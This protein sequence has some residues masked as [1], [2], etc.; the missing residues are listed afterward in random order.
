M[1]KRI[2]A[3]MSA[4]IIMLINTCLINVCQA[5][6]QNLYGDVQTIGIGKF[7]FNRPS[8]NSIGLLWTDEADQF[9]E[10]YSLFR[11]KTVNSVGTG[12][13][14]LIATIPS[15]KVTDG[16]I[17][18]YI[19]VFENAKPVQY[20]Y[21]IA[22]NSANPAK[23]VPVGTKSLIASNI[24]VCIDPGHY[25]GKNL[26]EDEY[27]YCEGDF[28]LKVALLLYGELRKYGIY[29]CLT[30][31]TPHITIAGFTDDALDSG[32]ISLR[33]EY[34]YAM[35]CDLFISL[36]TNANGENANGYP[37]FGQPTNKNFPIVIVNIPA[38]NNSVI[39]DMAN[40]IGTNLVNENKKLGIST[41]KGYIG[42]RAGSVPSWD[43]QLNDGINNYGYT[44]SRL[45]SKGVDYYG[46]LRGAAKYNIPGMI[47]EHAF[48]SV[49]ETR[50]MALQG[51]G[52]LEA[53]WARA[54]AYGIA[55]GLGFVTKFTY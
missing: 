53:A 32:R 50:K 5:N 36:H 52:V 27:S 40:S 10:S 35:D 20:E 21:S 37:T 4:V 31:T 28:T 8:K 16:K 25:T 15:D 33:G 12:E 1:K 47:V 23:Y 55:H 43:V 30:R 46:V 34:A 22:V 18:S 9:A 14:T 42:S 3:I 24:K 39:L 38:K 26:V 19:D 48:H 51:N 29:S 49:P 11:R 17:N 7:E 41:A 13:W 44:V 6:A 54:D 45:S 2:I